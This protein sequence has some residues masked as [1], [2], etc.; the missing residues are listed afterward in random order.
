MT[1]YSTLFSDKPVYGRPCTIMLTG[2]ALPA[3]LGLNTRGSP[4]TSFWPIAA[5]LGRNESARA[6]AINSQEWITNF[7]GDTR[8]FA[9]AAPS[10]PIVNAVSWAAG[11]WRVYSYRLGVLKNSVFDNTAIIDN[12]AAAAVLWGRPQVK[13]PTGTFGGVSAYG[14][15]PADLGA[16]A[17]AA[18]DVFLAPAETLWTDAERAAIL[19]FAASGKGFVVAGSILNAAGFSG[20]YADFPTNKLL[21]GFGISLHARGLENDDF[22]Y[23]KGFSTRPNALDYQPDAATDYLVD[24]IRG[25]LNSTRAADGTDLTSEGLSNIQKA[26]YVCTTAL[27]LLSLADPPL[28]TTASSRWQAADSTLSKLIFEYGRRVYEQVGTCNKLNRNDTL[29][30]LMFTYIG[31]VTT[32]AAPAD[33]PAA[34]CSGFFPGL[35]EQLATPVP[36]EVKTV[37]VRGTKGWGG[38]RK[39]GNMLLLS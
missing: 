16:G 32:D 7:A 5:A 10:R 3:L 34:P 18:V 6:V 2:T 28:S 13:P 12:F 38:Q 37:T 20:T 11:P 22:G 36:G 17:T 4:G 9:L 15:T 31:K 35:S 1:G 30:N 26:A 23:I 39:G 24:Y 33:I 29:T 25:V 21:S 27:S 14:L 8:L 19:A